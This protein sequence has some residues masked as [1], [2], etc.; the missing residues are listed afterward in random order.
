MNQAELRA[1]CLSVAAE[2][3]ITNDHTSG[4]VVVLSIGPTEEGT[5]EVTVDGWMNELRD[6]EHWIPDCIAVDE[7]DQFF[8]AVGGDDYNGATEWVP[9]EAGEELPTLVGKDK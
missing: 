2:Y 3:L 4:G 8:K 7:Q 5:Q 1:E 6:P 9:I